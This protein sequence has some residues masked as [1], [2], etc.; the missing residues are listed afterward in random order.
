MI[1]KQ[2]G[3]T[4]L[5]VSLLCLGS[6]TWGTQNTAAEGHAQIDMALDYGI[7]FIDTAEMYPTNPLSKETQ[8]DTERVIGQWVEKSGRRD[9]VIIA[10]KVSGEGYMNV[11]DGAPISPATI[12]IALEASLRSMRTDAEADGARWADKDD[13]R[14]TRV[15]RLIRMV[16]IDELPQ[17]WSVLKGEMSFVGPRP[18]VPAFVVDLEKELPFYA[19]RHMVK[20][21]ITGW[22]QINYP[23]GASVEDSRQKLEYD[24]YYAKNYTPFLDIIILLQTARVIIWPEG[25]R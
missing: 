21:G 1:Y 12:R 7:N 10:T 3:R 5:N 17:V 11:R 13:P 20:P 25:A 6:M 15:G 8:G 18:E 22:A 2:L 23:Y 24:L 14:I 4:D 16:R 19:E 9:E